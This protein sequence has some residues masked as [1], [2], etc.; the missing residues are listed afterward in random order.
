MDYFLD[1]ITDFEDI[2]MIIITPPPIYNST[3][4]FW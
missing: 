2:N 1:K 3:S 4:S